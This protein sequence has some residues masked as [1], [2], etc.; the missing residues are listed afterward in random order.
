MRLLERTV[1]RV[2]E[3]HWERVGVAMGLLACASIGSQVLHELAS[4]RPS[5][6]SWPFI[7]G[8]AVVYSFWFLYGLRFRRLA[9]WLPNAAAAVLQAVLALAAALKARAG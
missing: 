9:I 5:S 7:L 3:A 2:R 1:D 4:P 8:F 6:L